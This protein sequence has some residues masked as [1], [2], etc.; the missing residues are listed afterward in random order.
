MQ[1]YIARRLLI[2]LPVLIGVTIF[3]YIFINL[4]PGDPVLAFI[5]PA[6]AGE[7]GPEWVAMRR[8]QLGLD[9][10]LPVRYALWLRE[11]AT[12]N[13]G[14]SLINGTPVKTM[15]G[16]RLG[17]TVLLMG[18]ALL[19]AIALGVPLGVVSAIRQYSWLDY[20]LT[21]FGFVTIS[22]PSF[23]LG[24]ALIYLLA[25]RLRLLPTSG[26]YTLGVPL[27]LGDL[28]AHLLLPV[29][30]LGLAQV[31]QLMRYARSSMLE[32]TRQ[33]YVT[34]A[35][36]KG[37]SERRVLLGHAF[38]NALLP[39]VTV[40]GVSLP[41][42]FG[43]AVITE[44]IFNWPGMGRLAIQSV[45]GRDYPLL[46]GI[47]LVTAILVLV[48]NLLTDLLYALIDPRIKYR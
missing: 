10:P 25:I 26:M 41:N 22:T 37:L 44:Q 7:L 8:A 2:L 6:T 15:I 36:A 43:G 12:G 39:L 21:V 20:A 11:V 1:Q 30:V 32:V 35:R 29:T 17:P 38:R 48:S 4:A 3:S 14:Y 27:T 40:I 46:M 24:L 33:D 23:F 19:V 47:I 31:P 13:L 34:T 18:S 16:Q 28:A 45:N 42:L 9:K 5:D